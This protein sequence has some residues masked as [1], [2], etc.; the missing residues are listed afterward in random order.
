[1]ATLPVPDRIHL[2]DDYSI[3]R[4]IVGGWQF[5]KG[6]GAQGTLGTDPVDLFSRLVELGFTT[7][8]CADIYQGVEEFIGGVLKKSGLG[9]G[10]PGIQVH[11]KFVPD[12]AIL[13][14][15]D[16]SYVEGIINRSLT[17][18]GVERLDL[19]QFHWWDYSI[20][21]YRD[22]AQWLKELRDQGKI[23]H[24]GVTNFDRAHLAEIVSDGVPIRSNQVQY[25]VL[26]GRPG[27]GLSEYCETQGISL[28]C[29]GALSGGFLTDQYVGMDNEPAEAAN[30][31]L[32]KYR[33]IIHELGG[34]DVYQNI[35]GA[36]RGVAN[37]HGTET[38][39]VALRWVLD[40]AQ[41]AAT[42][43]GID[44]VTQARDLLNVFELSLDDDDRQ[45]IQASL[46]QT[47]GPIG[48]V[49]ALERDREG[50]HGRIMRYNLN[51]E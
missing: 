42:I 44:S 29:Y 39:S 26:D 38:V 48:P 16:K 23:R 30:R 9:A 19:L 24:L 51:Q 15:I 18:L 10:N 25:S 7:F 17:R 45:A 50:P 13:P 3:S 34:W 31:S 2:T 43:T 32:I 33:L 20:P 12:L 8:D 27:R 4:I 21:G 14:T 49:Y 40:Q 28:L 37:R 5:S 46:D 35:L 22:V 1:V 11:T 36:L 47:V 6:H 41:V